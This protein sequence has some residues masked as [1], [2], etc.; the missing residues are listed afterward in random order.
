MRKG[1]LVFSVI[2]VLGMMG[3]CTGPAGPTG[4]TGLT[5]TTGTD[6][7]DGTDGAGTQTTYVFS[8]TPPV[9]VINGT[10]TVSCPTIVAD[11]TNDVYSTVACFLH[12]TG[13]VDSPSLP[14]SDTSDG[15]E[16]FY[17]IETGSVTLGWIKSGTPEPGPFEL[18]VTVVN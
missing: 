1:L 12:W 15:T 6:G 5:G 9:D 18:I 14:F 3:A 7:T 8:I 13:Y 16:Y 2:M 4:P 17:S 10:V 11:N